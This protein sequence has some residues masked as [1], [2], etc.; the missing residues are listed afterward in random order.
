MRLLYPS[1]SAGHPRRELYS[2]LRKLGSIYQS[3]SE[4]AKS[5]KCYQEAFDILE[6]TAPEFRDTNA[7]MVELLVLLMHNYTYSNQ[8]AKAKRS[9]R[10]AE[11]RFNLAMGEEGGQPFWELEK[12]DLAAVL[13]NVWAQTEAVPGF[14]WPPPSELRKANRG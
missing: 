13:Q 3:E 5:A 9:L 1:D 4:H 2:L 6:S 7:D 8:Y 11:K 14:K 12:Y 10:E